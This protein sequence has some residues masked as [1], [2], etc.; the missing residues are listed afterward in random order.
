MLMKS[1]RKHLKRTEE[2]EVKV[3]QSCP[4]LCDP[5]DYTVYGILQD[6]IAYSVLFLLQQIAYSFSSSFPYTTIKLLGFRTSLHQICH[7]CMRIIFLAKCNQDPEDSREVGSLW[8]AYSF[9]SRSSQSRNQTWV[10]HIAGGFFTNWAIRELEGIVTILP[11]TTERKMMTECE[12]K[13]EGN[14]Q[15][16]IQNIFLP[17]CWGP[18]MDRN[19]V[20]QSRLIR[21]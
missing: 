3:T 11:M 9:S 19:L 16:A 12:I 8:V 18:L 10:S 1:Y 4:T 15:Q 13:L 20:V 14:E 7:F 21:K 2:L 5:I 6:R 17:Q